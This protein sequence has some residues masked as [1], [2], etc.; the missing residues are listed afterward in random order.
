MEQGDLKGWL[1]IESLCLER[2]CEKRYVESG[3]EAWLPVL[4]R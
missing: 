2:P 3:G 4:L 1:Q